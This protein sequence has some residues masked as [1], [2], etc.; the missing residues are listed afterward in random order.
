MQANFLNCL[1]SVLK[2]EGGYV[3]HPED[4][5]GHTNKGVTLKTFRAHY[6]E[7]RTVDDLKAI[8]DEQLFRIYKDGY[9]DRMNADDLPA[10]ADLVVFDMAVNAGPGRARELYNETCENWGR[11][12]SYDA[13]SVEK[14]I[15]KYTQARE[16]YYRTRAKFKTFGKGWLR[17]AAACMDE[18]LELAREEW[19]RA[20]PQ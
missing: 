8:T 19:R 14:F 4:P 20:N 16:R 10:G 18:A 11:P 17:R 7:E 5:G 15:A 2:Y 12:Y 6:G 3:N 1:Q 9:W 13:L